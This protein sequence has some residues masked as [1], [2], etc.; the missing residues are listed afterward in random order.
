MNVKMIKK[1]SYTIDEV[2][3]NVIP[4][5]AKIGK[6]FVDF[7]GD[8]MR[9]ES[10]RY[11]LFKRVGCTCISC[12]IHG[13][14]FRKERHK[15]D[16]MFHFNLYAID[17]NGNEILMTKDHIIPKSKGGKNNLSNYQVMCVI[18]N[19]NKGNQL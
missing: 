11:K 10:Q 8:L 2:L 15:H 6:H 18:C 16:I 19:N 13:S 4:Y 14:F 5:D 3:S 17:N 12:G 9:M 1:E 7:D